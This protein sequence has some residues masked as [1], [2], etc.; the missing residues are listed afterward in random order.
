MLEN[1]YTPPSA[2][3]GSVLLHSTRLNELRII[4]DWLRDNALRP[5]EPESS[6]G[7][8]IYTKSR[9]FNI[10]KQPAP[11]LVKQLDPDAVNRAPPGVD[12]EPQDA[13]GIYYCVFP[14][15]H[16]HHVL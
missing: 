3:I 13:V 8:R 9:L 10:S 15:A 4:A 1:P 16:P 11:N 5:Q 6:G 14:S 12:L 2:V 7:Y